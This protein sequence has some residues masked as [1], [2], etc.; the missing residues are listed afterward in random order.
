[1]PRLQDD[2][3]DA[4][5]R[6]GGANGPGFVI[7]ALYK[8]TDLPDHRALQ[9]QLQALCDAHDV[10]GTLLLADE[11]INGTICAA[12]AGMAAVLDWIE[13]DGRFDG[14]SLKFSLTPKQAF[15]RM[16]VR[17]KKEIVTMGQPGI[18][19]ARATGTYVEP[20]DWNRLVDD[21][22][23]MVIDTR[24]AYETAIGSFAGAVDPQTD[25]FREFPAWAQAL[26]ET[27]DRPKKLAMFCTGGI[28][29]EKASALMQQ[30]GFDEVYHLKGGILKYLEEVPAKD[31]RWQGECFVFDG[32]VAVDHELRPGG[33]DMCHACRMPLS[34]ED[35]DHPAYSAGVS[36]HHCIDRNDA[37]SRSR[38]AE[39]Q[40]QITLARARGEDHLGRSPRKKADA[41]RNS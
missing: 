5:R 3:Q 27:K 34:D 1:M 41:N 16:K 37:D 35:R 19:P 39:R 4:L 20:A 9:P 11:G 28:R 18:N 23:V 14:L 26:A 38:F 21:P 32:R 8:F 33:Y 30:M 17:L 31:S 10:H 12:P 40:K 15:L 7:A 22:D 6:L 36:C 25:S 2:M 13:A 29:C 24:N